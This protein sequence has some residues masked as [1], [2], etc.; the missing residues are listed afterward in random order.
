MKGTKWKV[1]VYTIYAEHFHKTPNC[2]KFCLDM[3][4]YW[5]QLTSSQPHTVTDIYIY[6]HQCWAPFMR[7]LCFQPS[8][9]SIIRAVQ[10]YTQCKGV[11]VS[12][13]L[14]FKGSWRLLQEWGK[15][16]KRDRLIGCHNPLLLYKKLNSL[17]QGTSTITVG[18]YDHNESS[19]HKHSH[20]Y[21]RILPLRPYVGTSDSSLRM[22][23]SPPTCSPR[24]HRI[25]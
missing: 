9:V 1:D 12:T 14:N 25:I 4:W 20:I 22:V 3:L 8:S 6:I 24:F 21:R 18:V 7:S 17:L 10:L 16:L 2:W 23:V 19:I 5:N 11:L 15:P 13:C